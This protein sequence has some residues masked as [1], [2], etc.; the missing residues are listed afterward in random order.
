MQF[1][2]MRG[3]PGHRMPPTD[4]TSELIL[5]PDGEVRMG[6]GQGLQGA[7]GMRLHGAGH[8]AEDQGGQDGHEPSQSAMLGAVNQPSKC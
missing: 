7:D 5:G 4:L 1:R 8:L 2:R 6:R 3:E